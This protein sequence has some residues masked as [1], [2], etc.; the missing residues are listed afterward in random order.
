M[1]RE[2]WRRVGRPSHAQLPLALLAHG[3]ERKDIYSRGLLDALG[4]ANP[5]PHVVER[6]NGARS[7]LVRRVRALLSVRPP[8][9]SG[10]LK[11]YGSPHLRTAKEPHGRNEFFG[12]YHR[13][14]ISSYCDSPHSRA[15]ALLVVALGLLSGSHRDKL[16]QRVIGLSRG[17]TPLRG[18]PIEIFPQGK[19][20]PIA[21]P[22][23]PMDS[24][25][26]H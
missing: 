9:L 1:V 4:R 20:Q 10:L 23:C 24:R 26:C 11:S 5:F 25:L 22:D 19:K 12:Y 18:C 17:R 2:R 7:F 8:S 15:C 21:S 16:G 3:H 6:A 13:G 14:D